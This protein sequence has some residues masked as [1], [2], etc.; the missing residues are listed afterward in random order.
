VKH[1]ITPQ[2][3]SSAL[4]IAER[5]VH[6]VKPGH[7]ADA[8]LRH[9]LKLCRDL[10]PQEAKQ[11]VQA[12]FAYYRW[13]G[14][15]ETQ[16]P[17]QAR[18]R[19][20]LEL[21]ERFAREP[22]L[23]ADADLLARAVPAWATEEMEIT[24]AFVRALQFEPR[25]WLRAR[26]GH[27][28]ALAKRL[29]AC[30]VFGSGLLSDILEYRGEADLFRT[31]EFHHGEFELQ[32]IS[33]QAVGLICA[34]KPCETWWDACA[35]EGGKL[36]HLSQLMEN[37]GLLWASDRAEWRLKILKR[38]AARATVFN[39][40]SA[41]WNGGPKLPTKTRFDG[42]LIDAPCSGSGTWQRNPDARWTTCLE[43]VK[44]LSQLQQRLLANASSAVK[45]GGK[46]IYA[47]CTLMRSETAT[48]AQAFEKQFPEFEPLA[49]TDP[50]RPSS[51]PQLPLQLWPQDH[52]GNGMFMA[53]WRRKS[54]G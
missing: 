41:L 34:P 24:P 29:G 7:P 15:L 45:P 22:K 50:L 21:A 33:S 35:G 28:V 25:L 5:I 36:L 37:K 54:D 8:V 52:G 12:V 14:W 10:S 51:S 19:E 18:I 40:R 4:R 44:E 30:H 27:G 2:S 16:K 47:V 32:D 20:A 17:H 46:L 31:T 38:R 1:S 48:V 13:C 26:K 3:W 6:R 49:L 9:E 42:V 11:V 53:A 39:Y 43:D 23:F